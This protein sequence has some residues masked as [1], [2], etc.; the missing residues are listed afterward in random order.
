MLQ[1]AK[2]PAKRISLPAIRIRRRPL[3]RLF[4]GCLR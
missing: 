1:S 3:R 4:Y 2:V